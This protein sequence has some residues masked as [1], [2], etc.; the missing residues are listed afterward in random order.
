MQVTHVAAVVTPP[1]KMLTW[2]AKHT[3]G[4]DLGNFDSGYQGYFQ[5][6]DLDREG[7]L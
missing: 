6:T 4:K 1:G 7:T 3:A 2:S 5:C